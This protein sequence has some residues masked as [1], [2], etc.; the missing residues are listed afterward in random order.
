MGSGT[1]GAGE[2]GSGGAIVAYPAKNGVIGTVSIDRPDTTVKGRICWKVV[3]V[4]SF[5]LFPPPF[6]RSGNSRSARRGVPQAVPGGIAFLRRTDGRL[7][8]AAI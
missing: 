3:Y 1:H 5:D 8:A 7:A 4:A 2:A 6:H